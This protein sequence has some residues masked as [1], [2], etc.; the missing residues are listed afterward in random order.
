MSIKS[1]VV[2]MVRWKESFNDENAYEEDEEEDLSTYD[3]DD[4]M[5]F[6]FHEDE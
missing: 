2:I 5:D 6:P 1:E 4:E 3:D